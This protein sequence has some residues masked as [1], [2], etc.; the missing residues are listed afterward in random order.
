MRPLE[1]PPG[2]SG[3]WV[4]SDAEATPG[5]PL[6]LL[7]D[8]REGLRDGAAGPVRAARGSETRAVR[9]PRGS[10]PGVDA[11]QVDRGPDEEAR[12]DEQG[13]NERDLS[14]D[15]GRAEAVRAGAA[16]RRGR[17]RAVPPAR[18]PRAARRTGA[19]PKRSAL[20][21]DDGEGEAEHARDPRS[22]ARSAERPPGS[23]RRARRPRPRRR[24]RRARRRPGRARGSRSGA[25]GRSASRDAPTAARTVSSRVRSGTAREQHVGDVEARD[26]E[27]E[28]HGARRGSRAVRGSPRRAARA[29]AG[30]RKSRSDASCGCSFRMPAMIAEAF[31]LG[32][33]ER[34][35][36]LGAA[37][38]P[39]DC[40]RRGRRG[41]R[42]RAQPGTQSSSLSR[43]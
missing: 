36:G 30:S 5:S 20:T 14:G 21:S 9:T 34:H 29:S 17:P 24:G 15:E 18:S 12:A 38:R 35:V 31:G 11:L 2:P 10:N 28:A 4:V 13:Q 16:R 25:A 39:R 27:H 23:R 1:L 43:E 41:L 8:A 19:M 33:G 22:P 26:Q 7:D 37:R 6:Q 3:T 32:R 40:G 42:R